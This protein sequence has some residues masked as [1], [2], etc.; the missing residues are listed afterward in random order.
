MENE[1]NI[2][3]KWMSVRCEV[4][5]KKYGTPIEFRVSVD[6]HRYHARQWEHYWEFWKV[7]D[8]CLRYPI[9]DLLD[10]IAATYEAD[11]EFLAKAYAE[12]WATDLT[13]REKYL[14]YKQRKVITPTKGL[15]SDDE[16]KH[17]KQF[18]NAVVVKI[19][20]SQQN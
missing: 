11:K 20:A 4:C 2:E 1:V 19:D 14:T 8:K 16:I 3:E 15:T 5:T 10:K 13:V 17:Y 18:F 12:P 6:I 9:D 7:H